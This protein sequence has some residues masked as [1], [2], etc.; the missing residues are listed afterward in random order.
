MRSNRIYQENGEKD[1][2]RNNKKSFHFKYDFISLF[3]FG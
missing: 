1:R 3:D 2:I